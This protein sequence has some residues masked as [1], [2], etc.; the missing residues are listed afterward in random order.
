M[1]QSQ[2]LCVCST[3]SYSSPHLPIPV[4]LQEGCFSPGTSGRQAHQPPGTNLTLNGPRVLIYGCRSGSP[5]LRGSSIFTLNHP[6]ANR[7]IVLR[8][9]KMLSQSPNSQMSVSW[10]SPRDSHCRHRRFGSENCTCCLASQ[11]FQIV[12]HIELPEYRNSHV[13]S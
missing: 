7:S 12:T 9:E 8:P 13:F 2:S 10:L 6:S 3:A 5:W 11:A 1:S 4:S